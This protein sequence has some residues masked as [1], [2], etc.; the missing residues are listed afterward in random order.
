MNDFANLINSNVPA[1]H[2]IAAIISVFTMY[3]GISYVFSTKQIEEIPSNYALITDVPSP[4]VDKNDW[5]AYNNLD[6]DDD[7]WDDDDEDDDEDDDD[8]DDYWDDDDDD[9]WDD[10][11]DDYWDDDE[12]DD[13]DDDIDDDDDDDDYWDDDD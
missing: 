11:E 2:A 4:V 9:Y 10:D 3:K 6:D 7:Y 1:G 13:I 5:V 12:D 8:D